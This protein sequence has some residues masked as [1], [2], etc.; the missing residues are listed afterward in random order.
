MKYEDNRPLLQDAYFHVYGSV[1]NTGSNTA[2]NAKIHIIIYQ[3]AVVAKDTTINLGSINGQ[4]SY[5]VDSKVYYT[6]SAI[7]TYS[8]TFQFT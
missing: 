2:Y 1:V 5:N 3:G 4:S 6:G 7:T 8:A